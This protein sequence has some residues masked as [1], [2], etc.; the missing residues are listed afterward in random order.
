VY[1][2]ADESYRLAL[3]REGQFEERN[4]C[5]FTTTSSSLIDWLSNEVGDVYKKDEMRHYLIK[6]GA[7]VIDVVT[8]KNEPE[9][10]WLTRIVGYVPEGA[11]IVR[12]GKR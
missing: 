10:E 2:N 12:L 5:L 9:A 11:K 4:W 6:T 3:W 7:G 8:N 1:R